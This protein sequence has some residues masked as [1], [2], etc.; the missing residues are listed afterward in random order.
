MAKA[1]K[2]TAKAGLSAKKSKSVKDEVAVITMV[3]DE[4]GSMASLWQPT[5]SGFNE[6]VE[7]LKK[8]LKGKSY[9]SAITFDSRGV[10]KLQVGAPIAEAIQLNQGNYT[11]TGGTPLIDAAVKAIHATEEVVT[12][13]GGTKVIVVVQTDGEENAS[14]EFT[15]AH[16]KTMV[17][18][19]TAKGWEFVFIG[20]GINAFAQG[21]TFGFQARN[22]MSYVPDVAGTQST[23][24]STAVNSAS[25]ISGQ[26][27]SMGYSSAQRTTSGESALL[28]SLGEK[29]PAGLSKSTAKRMAGRVK[30]PPSS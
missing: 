10:R 2:K 19:R 12:K 25:Y 22:T 29:A 8:K 14:R 15:L 23:F 28:D 27:R 17:E 6:Y 26:S 3:V 30:T 24:A 16:L 9:F 11:P 13:E 21:A 4:S 5:M 20:A 18:E 1:K 7:T